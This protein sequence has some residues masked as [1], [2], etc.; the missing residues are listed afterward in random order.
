MSRNSMDTVGSLEGELLR[1]ITGARE[2]AFQ[3]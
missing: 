2:D 3:N 1:A